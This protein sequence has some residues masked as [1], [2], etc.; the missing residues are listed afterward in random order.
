MADKEIRTIMAPLTD[1]H[2]L[3][4]NS[5]VAEVLEFTRPAPL[6]QTPAWL[7]G[8]LAWRGWQVPVICLEQLIGDDDSSTITPKT[9][10]LIIKTLG[11]S[12]QLNY[13]GLIIQ[14]LPRLKTVSADSLIEKQTDELPETLFSMV[15]IDELQ[16][17]IPELGRLTHF[18]EHAAYDN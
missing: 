15:S 8:E 10:I 6:K 11:E 18:V 4:P 5:A 12:T 14:G 13:I 2:V 9:R 3:L 17:I 16:A 7:L 1:G